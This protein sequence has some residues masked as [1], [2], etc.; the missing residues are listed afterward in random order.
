MNREY[1]VAKLCL[2]ENS[3]VLIVVV[4]LTIFLQ[5]SGR[6][7]EYTRKKTHARRRKI[8]L[9]IKL[10]FVYARFSMVAEQLEL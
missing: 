8:N 5:V 7:C 9:F 3:F 6:K 4:L 2:G 10:D 1:Y